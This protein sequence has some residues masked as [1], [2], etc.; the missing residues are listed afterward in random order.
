MPIYVSKPDPANFIP[1]PMGLHRAVC[2]DVEDLG[3]V[4]TRRG[5]KHKVKITWQSEQLNHEGKRYT[6]VNRYTASLHENAI[7]RQHLINWRGKDF[8]SEELKSFDLEKLLGAN[9]QINVVH[10]IKEIDGES[11]TFANVTSI[12]PPPQGMERLESLHYTRKKDRDAQATQFPPQEPAGAA[13]PPVDEP[14][15]EFDMEF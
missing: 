15:P 9:C 1:A 13:S 8:S 12:V 14:T 3:V 4:D 2:V 7:L 6:I 10:N 5:P 11:V